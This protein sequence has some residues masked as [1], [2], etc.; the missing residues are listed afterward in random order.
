MEINERDLSKVV[1]DGEEFILPNDNAW[2]IFKLGGR[3][4]EKGVSGVGEDNL[5]E[6]YEN[7]TKMFPN[8]FVISL[9]CGRPL[10][11][12]WYPLILYKRREEYFRVNIHREICENCGWQG[13]VSNPASYPIFTGA[14]NPKEAF[15]KAKESPI[16]K[17]IKC[18]SDLGSR[19]LFTFTMT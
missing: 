6:L 14:V 12:K 16:G 15:N 9:H 3:Y 19:S 11:G 7:F 18:G 4:L 17:C 10:R 1:V 2:G 8:E 5:E 13:W